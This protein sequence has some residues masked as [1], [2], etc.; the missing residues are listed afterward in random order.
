MSYQKVTPSQAAFLS[1]ISSY[2]EP[3]NFHEAN[4][5]DVWKEAMQEEHKAPN[6]HKTKSITKLPKGKRAVGCKWIH[7]IKFNSDG[8]IERHKARLVARGFT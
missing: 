3:Q 5:K 1:T 4:N 8:L 2:N 7:K 6:Q